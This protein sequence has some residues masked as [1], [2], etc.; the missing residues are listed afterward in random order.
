MRTTTSPPQA[1]PLPYP[2]ARTGNVPDHREPPRARALPPARRRDRIH[3]SLLAAGARTGVASPIPD[4]LRDH[5]T[6]GRAAAAGHGWDF[7]E[8]A[9]VGQRRG[10]LRRMVAEDR[11]TGLAID[12]REWRVLGI[13]FIGAPGTIEPLGRDDSRTQ[14]H[15]T[16]GDQADAVVAV[17][18]HLGE[19]RVHRAVGA[20]YGGNAALALGIRYPRRTE[21]IVVIAAAHRPHPLGTGV[22]SVQRAILEFARD[23]GREADGVA[24]ARALA[25]TTYKTDAGLDERFGFEADLSSGKAGPS[26]GPLSVEARPG[27]RRAVRRENLPD[28]VRLDRS[29]RSPA[30]GADRPFMADRLGGGQVGAALAGRGDA[31]PDRGPVRASGCSIPMGGH[32]AFLLHAPEYQA[33]LRESLGSSVAQEA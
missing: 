23:Q 1:Y 14:F 20:S 31:P 27:V 22:R 28:A 2:P 25:F 9:R 8:P 4:S 26:G 29:V 21:G 33:A 32:D 3:A 19:R 5:G 18:D 16:P 17:L 10:P 12:S 13:D 7:S 15:I 6:G 11:R 30:R 24:I